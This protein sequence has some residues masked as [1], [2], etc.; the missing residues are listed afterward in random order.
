MQTALDK[1]TAALKLVESQVTKKVDN[2]KGDAQIAGE[3][4]LKLVAI[5]SEGLE[6]AAQKESADASEDGSE[7][8]ED[9]R[10]EIKEKLDNIKSTLIGLIKYGYDHMVKE[11]EAKSN[12]HAKPP[13]L[14]N[15]KRW[16]RRAAALKL[17]NPSKK[18][19]DKFKKAVG[20]IMP[21]GQIVEAAITRL[22]KPIVA[23]GDANA[24]LDELKKLRGDNGK[25]SLVAT[26]LE[27]VKNAVKSHQSEVRKKLSIC[28]KAKTLLLLHLPRM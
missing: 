9:K 1:A 25:A 26:V 17:E 3:Y 28:T 7:P 15:L 6:L 23:A 16:A 12:N 24:S 5:I 8:D 14:T 18:V 27:S 20:D 13:P 19:S 10:S 21:V 22:E 4:F 11:V 2:L